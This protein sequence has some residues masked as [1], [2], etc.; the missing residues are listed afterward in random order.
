MWVHSLSFY[1]QKRCLDL[2]AEALRLRALNNSQQDNSSSKAN[3]TPSQKTPTLGKNINPFW[4]S[5]VV[6]MWVAF[7]LKLFTLPIVL[8]NTFRLYWNTAINSISSIAALRPSQNASRSG[9]VLQIWWPNLW[10]LI[11]NYRDACKRGDFRR[12]RSG[13]NSSKWAIFKKHQ[14]EKFQMLLSSWRGSLLK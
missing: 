14:R 9:Q 1:L 11:S 5:I 6:G 12:T 8:K 7:L 13:G 4:N 2:A 3:A 10:K